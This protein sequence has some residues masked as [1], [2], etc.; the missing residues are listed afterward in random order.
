MS[1]DQIIKI[2]EIVG[3]IVV[4]FFGGKFILRLNK[5]KKNNTSEIN[6][7]NGTNQVA[8]NGTNNTVDFNGGSNE[9]KKQD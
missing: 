8:V 4:A 5:T 9:S 2:A 3:A 6:Q 7:T 1:T